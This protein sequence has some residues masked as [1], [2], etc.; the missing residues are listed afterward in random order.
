MLW[1]HR[2]KRQNVWI[3]FAALPQTSWMIIAKLPRSIFFNQLPCPF[4]LCMKHTFT[5]Q[6]IEGFRSRSRQELQRS[7][8]APD[9]SPPHLMAHPWQLM[10]VCVQGGKQKQGER[11]CIHP[12]C[13]FPDSSHTKVWGLPEQ[14]VV[15]MKLATLKGFVNLGAWVVQDKLS[16]HL[17]NFSFLGARLSS[18][19]SDPLGHTGLLL[20]VQRRAFP[21]LCQLP[22]S[23]KEVMLP[24]RELRLNTLVF[25]HALE[26][27]SGVNYCC[28]V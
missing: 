23:H 16:G 11:S 28:D 1:R 7:C 5:I 4:C 2:P 14:W 21:S 24:A 15:C 6:G 17:G 18:S 3:L 22:A 25:P 13:A 27:K 19:V 12:C 26:G 20:L 9:W 10:E 8:A